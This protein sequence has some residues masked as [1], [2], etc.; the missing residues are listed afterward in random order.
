MARQP[1][2]PE[3]D[4]QRGSRP[5]VTDDRDDEIP[6]PIEFDDEEE[7]S[8]FLRGQRRIPV[9]RGPLPKKAA[10]R[11][12]QV[13]IGVA[14]VGV[15]GA[16]AL[17]LVAYFTR[18]WRFRIESRDNIEITGV[19]NVSRKQV[20]DV[21]SSDIGRNVF[22]VDLDERKHKLEEIPWVQSAA[23]MRLLPDHVKVAIQ[24]RT[25]VAFVQLGSKIDLIDSTGVIMDMPAGKQGSY[26]F[27]VI[28]GMA[29]SEPLSTRAPRMQ[30]FAQLVR[31]LDADGANYSRDLSEV[32]L[33]D[34]DDVR[35][36]VADPDGAVLLHLGSSNFLARYKVYVAHVQE[37]RQQFQKLDSVDLRYDGQVI[38]N[39]DS[40][41]AAPTPST[42]T[43]SSPAP[44]KPQPVKAAKQKAH[45]KRTGTTHH[46]H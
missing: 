21:F 38:V 33:S 3:E 35:A 29:E 19:Q 27:P 9:R 46:R 31:E 25:P 36:T 44:A 26:S 4:V 32:D 5:I 12:K 43:T 17:G 30:Q 37:W 10:N 40:K 16:V 28:V 23:V 20:L 41:A 22:R 14:I 2:T 7:Q 11:L 6:R 45:G 15:G 42:S 34:P 8:P 18:G 1:F 24:E 39:P 13:F